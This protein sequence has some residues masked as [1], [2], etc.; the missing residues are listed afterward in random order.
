[1]IIKFKLFEQLEEWDD[2]WGEEIRKYDFIKYP[3]NNRWYN[4]HS[5][6]YSEKEEKELEKNILRFKKDFEKNNIE[7]MKQILK[8]AIAIQEERLELLRS[9]RKE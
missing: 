1:M 5:K 6:V 8:K 9:F 3:S 7:L 4:D 2:P